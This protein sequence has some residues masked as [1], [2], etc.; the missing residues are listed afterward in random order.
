MAG[1]KT[2]YEAASRVK[3]TLIFSGLLVTRPA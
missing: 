1:L 3:I 2:L